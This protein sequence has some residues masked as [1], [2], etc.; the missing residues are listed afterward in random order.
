MSPA[1]RQRRHR[2]RIG[3][4]EVNRRNRIYARKWRRKRRKVARKAEREAKA[5]IR[6]RKADAAAA[7]IAALTA[8]VAALANG[9]SPRRGIRAGSLD[10]CTVE[11]VT[12]AEALP[13]VAAHE[14][15]GNIGQAT[16][17]VGLYSPG[18]ELHGVACFGHGSTGAIR[19]RIGSPALCLERG[20]C[21]PDAPP[22]AASFLINAACRLV[23]RLTG[24]ARFFA[25]ADPMAGEYGAVYQ[26]AGWLYLGQGLYGASSR[27]RRYAV[28][29]PGA[30]PAEPAHWQTTRA[31]RRDGRHLSFAEARAQGWRIATREAKHVYAVNVGRDRK[32]WLA[33]LPVLAY[34]KP[35]FRFEQAH[36]E[37]PIGRNSAQLNQRTGR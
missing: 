27:T 14:W 23:H 20:A 37:R 3:L 21:T 28:L 9:G 25:Y 7:T 10:G 35:A 26:A 17:F 11:T 33:A 19:K 34:P 12:I 32:T 30:D 5:A 8:T 22:N 4:A 15:L 24:T 36:A 2:A 31:L 1:E 16:L 13:L 6:A 18:R 29:M